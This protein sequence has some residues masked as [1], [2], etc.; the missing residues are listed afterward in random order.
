M[1]KSGLLSAN[2][3]GKMDFRKGIRKKNIWKRMKFDALFKIVSD[4]KLISKCLCKNQKFSNRI[5]LG[6]LSG[7]LEII[8]R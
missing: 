4:F 1:I 7:F 5:N 2:I 6:V 8:G 3:W